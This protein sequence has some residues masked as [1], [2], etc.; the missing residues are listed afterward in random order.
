MLQRMIKTELMEEACE[1]SNA[2][3]VYFR[4]LTRNHM[5]NVTLETEYEHA[6]TYA[7][8][9][10]LRFEG[11]IRIEFEDLPS[12]FKNLSV[13]KLILQPLLENAINYGL[14]NK[15]ETGLLRVHFLY[16]ENSLNIIVEDNGEELSDETLK[17]L[18]EKLDISQKTSTDCEM[19]G[20]LNIQR[21]LSIF[22]DSNEASSIDHTSLDKHLQELSF[23]LYQGE[24]KNFLQLL[25]HLEEECIRIR[26]MHS[27]SAIQI[28]NSVALMFLQY[29]DLYNLQEKIVSKIALYPLYYIAQKFISVQNSQK[30]IIEKL[31]ALISKKISI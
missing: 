23:Y 22:S 5:D 24:R 2:L 1:M 6:K 20:L 26:S 14:N 19:T 3:A 10:G 8:I 21:R 28:Y 29:I 16:S 25:S 30:E 12:D 13:P 31:D 18:K 7:Y 15:M 11:R 17:T 27:I 4:Y 9:Q